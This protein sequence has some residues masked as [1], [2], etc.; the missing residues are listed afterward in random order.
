M[1]MN[2]KGGRSRVRGREASRKAILTYA[3]DAM[4]GVEWRGVHDE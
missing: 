1:S 3:V 2:R 4:A